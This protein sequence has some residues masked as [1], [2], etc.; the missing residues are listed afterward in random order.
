MVTFDSCVTRAGEAE[1]EE[2]EEEDLGKS[3]GTPKRLFRRKVAA[4]VLIID[5]EPGLPSGLSMGGR[6]PA[7]AVAAATSDLLRFRD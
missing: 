5:V 3:V 1:R 7:P 2:E 6:E 4:G